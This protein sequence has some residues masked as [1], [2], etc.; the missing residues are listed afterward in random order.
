MAKK[1]TRAKL[2]QQVED[3]GTLRAKIGL[4]E[5][6][7]RELSKSVRCGLDELKLEKAESA[8]FVAVLDER[9]SLTIDPE[10]FRKKFGDAAFFECSRVDAKCARAR[11]EEVKL[12]QCGTVS[13]S[14][15]L[16][17]AA[18]PTAT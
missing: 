5:G 9:S 6:S 15:T 14:K 11:F 16:R 2:V 10:K 17:V 4:L 7:E 12:Q 3:L 18:R 8:G 1:I 13:T